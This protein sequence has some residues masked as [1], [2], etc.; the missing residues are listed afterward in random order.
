MMVHRTRTRSRGPRRGITTVVVLICLLVITLISGVLLR[1]GVAYRETVRAQE[2]RLQAEWLAQ[3]GLDRALFRLAASAGYTGETWQLAPADLA[4]GAAAD[5]GKESGAVVRIKVEPSGS[6]SNIKLIKVEADYP[7]DPPR[8]ARYSLSV[9]V[10]PG[11]L[12][13]GVSQ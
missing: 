2:R 12:K 7:P 10:E 5:G 9:Q 3:S 6:S 1:V 11:S 13:R 4:F 8:R